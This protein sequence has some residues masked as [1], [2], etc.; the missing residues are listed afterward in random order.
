VSPHTVALDHE[1]EHPEEVYVR[2]QFHLLLY[3]LQQL[4]P[5]P[6]ARLLGRFTQELLDQ[7]LT[8]DTPR[9]PLSFVMLGKTGAGRAL[10]LLTKQPATIA[11]ID[12]FEQDSV[13]WDVGANVGVYALYAALRGDVKV[14]AFE[15]AAVNYFMLAAN[16]EANKFEDRMDCLLLGLG[17]E[18]TIARLEVSQFDSAHSFS[19]RGKRKRPRAGRQTA[20]VLSIDQLIEEY[21]LACP[22]YV[23]IDVPGL[24]ESIIAG[25]ARTLRRRELR[26]LHIEMSEDSRGGRAIVDELKQTGFIAASRHGHGGSSDVTFVRRDE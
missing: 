8:V 14:V 26:E 16:C 18:R 13:F 6:R 15:P 5:A 11:W 19:F 17:S 23:K 21:G 4:P 20:F 25:A 2:K 7:T 9:G 12:S 3:R 22:N 1:H 10:S 24:S